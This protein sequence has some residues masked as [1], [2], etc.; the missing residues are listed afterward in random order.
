MAETVDLNGRSPEFPDPVNRLPYAFG[1]P[2]GT[3]V[4]RKKPEDFQVIENLGYQPTGEGEHLFLVI[5]KQNRTTNEVAA[6][7][8][9]QAGVRKRNVSFAGMKDKEAL[10]TQAFSIHMPGMPD[11]D[12]RDLESDELRILDCKRHRRKIRRGSLRGNRFVLRVRDVSAD[13]QLVQQRVSEVKRFGTPNFFG[14]QRFGN[15]GENLRQAERLFKG[16]M[17][18]IDRQLRSILL[19]SVRAWLFN[20]VLAERVRRADWNK[21]LDGDVMLLAGSNRQFLAT[22]DLELLQRRLE[23]FDINPSAPLCGSKSRSLETR[24]E[25]AQVEQVLSGHEF[26]LEGLERFGLKE[27]RRSLRLVASGLEHKWQGDDLILSFSLPAGSYATTL[28]REIVT[29]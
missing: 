17:A 1:G 11:P 13:R 14:P 10:T 22:E 15:R 24:N 3:G 7:L 8:G 28:L 29:V 6:M 21:V 20:L 4:I 26:W 23:A 2:A 27:D 12:L 5:Q 18:G 9:R 19:S 25:A 16:E